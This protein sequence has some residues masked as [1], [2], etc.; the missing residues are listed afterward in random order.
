MSKYPA[1]SALTGA[2][3]GTAEMREIMSDRA[4][5]G[6]MLEVESALARAEASLGLVPPEVARQIADAA[7]LERLSLDA[8]ASSTRVV[9]YPVVGLVAEL[10]RA[11]GAEASKYL[12]LG[13]TTQDIVDTALVLQL[14][15]GFS[16]L[17]RD[18]IGVARSLAA[19]AVR[20]RDT[21]VA[22]RTHLQHA[23]PT[24]FGLKC[25]AWAAP[26][27]AHIERLDQAAPR[28]FVVQF[29]GAAGTNASLG[30]RGPAV[31]VALARELGLGVPIMPWH[32]SRD[33]I[34][35]GAAI[36]GLI[37]GSL[38]KFALD[39]ALMAQ[40]EVGELSEPR[41]D[42]GGSSS[43]MP[44]K[45]NPILSEYIGAAAR[46]VAGLVPVMFSAMAQEHERA[47]GGW[48][49]ESA[50]LPQIFVLTAGALAHS[51]HLAES[52]TIDSTRMRRNIDLSDGLIMSEALAALLTPALGRAE[53]HH[54]VQAAC[55]RAIAQRTSLREVASRDTVI[56]RNL[57]PEGIDAAF[58]P[59]NYLGAAGAYVDRVV[60]RIAALK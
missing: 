56:M 31:A 18:L 45:R 57:P 25:A 53:A 46:M 21:P 16:L 35:E 7:K 58:D 43:T 14:R 29:G 6:A 38:S 54:L 44:Q 15:R 33:T 2:L 3:F 27:V 26:L 8:V 52:M 41:A 13:A 60:A 42:G 4:L 36:A 28:M 11:A 32:A 59:E 17:R 39:F 12:H 19:K 10:G 24:S 40:T 30:T 37:C 47:A 49:A 23:V 22:A 48:Q 1:D 50:A 51:R 55:D 9:G 5:I 20:F 34:V